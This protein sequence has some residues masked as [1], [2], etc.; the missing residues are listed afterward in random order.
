[1][2]SLSLFAGSQY[3]NR[4][5]R[6]MGDGGGVWGRGG[7]FGERWEGIWEGEVAGEEK[8]EYTKEEKEE[9][10]KEVEE[11]RRRKKEV[12]RRPLD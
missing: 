9:D 7:G 2:Y 3:E 5:V 4:C 10:M 6:G 8:E 11:E 1:M 12:G